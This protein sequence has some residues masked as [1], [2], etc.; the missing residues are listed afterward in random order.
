MI[1]GRVLDPQS[2]AVPGTAVLVTNVETNTAVRLT[3]NDTG[4]YEANLLLP[5][6][7]QVT[8]EAAGFKKL[9]RS[10]I[11]LPVSTRLEINMT[12]ELG[13]VTETV[14]VTAEAPLL[15]TSTVSSGRVM[16][17]RSLMDLPVLGNNPMLLVKMTPGIQT[18]GINNYLGLHSISG[19]SGYSTAGNVGGNE[20]SID[21]VP[22]NGADRQSAY[23]PYS[24]TIQEF[25]VENVEF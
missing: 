21:G 23:L 17:N 6:S 12:L 18:N 3:A 5:G 20:W 2:G 9:V 4:Y 25:R 11:V 1:F 24:D 16:D 22:N 19:S 15:D 14:S 13:T 10:G 7:Y 8:A